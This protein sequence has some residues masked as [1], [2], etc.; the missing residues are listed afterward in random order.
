MTAKLIGAILTLAA[1]LG[2]ET[3]I[4][5]PTATATPIDVNAFSSQVLPGGSASREFT[6]ATGGTVGVTLTST[7]PTGMVLGLGLGIPR[8]DGSC[9]LSGAVATTAG[10]S[11]Q[12]SLNADTG[13]FC[14]KVYDA[15]GLSAPVAFTL[16]IS[17]P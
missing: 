2:C 1:C 13:L 6:L 12:L 3:T 16:S 15:G 5:S 11:T 10:E 9:A 8:A 4:T 17:R 14:V 7:T